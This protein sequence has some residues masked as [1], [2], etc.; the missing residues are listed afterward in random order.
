M[1]KFGLLLLGCVSLFFAC[2]AGENE[3]TVMKIPKIKSLLWRITGN[4]MQTPSYIF[5][6]MHLI[7]KDDY[8]WTP[9]MKKSLKATKEVCFEMDMDDPNVMMEIATAMI[10]NSGKK[11][12]EYFS[13]NDYTLLEK[14]ITD[15]L[16]MDASMIA[17]L[18]PSALVTLLATSSYN[19]TNMVS[20]ENN[21]MAEAQHQNKKITGLEK[22]AEQIALLE[23]LP[24]DS[25][26][27]EVVKIINGSAVNEQDEYDNLV[28]AYRKQDIQKLYSLMTLTGKPEMNLNSF[29][30]ERNEKWIERMEERMEQQPVFFAIGA[31][32]LWGTNGVLNLLQKKGYKVQAVR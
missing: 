8:L 32:H 19:C 5:G 14:Y 21:I 29:L 6:T 18:K 30:D 9:A 3:D 25:V 1:K 26:I 7:C 27:N 15:S 22:P 12:Q 17:Q 4:D 24:T 16:G 11:L 20:Y 13:V 31:G 23:T 28:N 10:D 2:K